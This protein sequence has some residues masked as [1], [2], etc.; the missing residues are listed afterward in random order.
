M[1]GTIL[2]VGCIWKFVFPEHNVRYIAVN[3]GVDTLNKSAM[4]ITPFRNILNEMYAADISVKIKSAY[5]ARFQQGKFMGTTAPYGYIKDP[6]DHN[7]LLIDDKVAHVV[8]EIFDLA[9]VGN[10][11]SKIRKHLNRQHILRPAAYAVTQGDTSYERHFGDNEESRYIWSDGSV[12][13]ILRSPIYAGNLVGYKRIAVSMKSKKRPSKLPEEWEVIPDTHEGIVTQE[14]FDTVQQLMT[15]RRREQ[16]AG[17]FENIFAGIIKCADC[18]YALRAMNAH[19]RKRP[20]VIDC[21]QYSCNN[22]ARNGKG[23]CTAHNVEARDLF[24]A[25]L[26]DINR[27]ADMAV[28]DEKAVR[29]I[30]KRLTETDQSRAKA[31]EKERKKLNK[32]LAELDRLFSSLYE[33]KVMERITERNF[34]MMSGKYQKEQLEIEARLSEVTETLNDSYEKSQG[35]P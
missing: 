33:D 11:I 17:G 10:G 31:L 5:R 22:Y 12:R 23:V 21:V 9:L 4:D 26:A 7:H 29:A 18:G 2:I 32:R 3:D 15:S 6:A 8:R 16:N 20:E 1:A 28:N 30:E 13:S 27:F 14:E 34:E 25:V 35:I 19:R 24:N